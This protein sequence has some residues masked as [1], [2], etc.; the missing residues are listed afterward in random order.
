M[1]K[2]VKNVQFQLNDEQNKQFEAIKAAQNLSTNN[3]FFA[4]ILAL[5]AEKQSAAAAVK[6]ALENVKTADVIRTFVKQT[7]RTGI[8]G[9]KINQY[10]AN[11]YLA[12]VRGKENARANAKTLILIFAEFAAQIDK[13]NDAVEAA[14]AADK[15]N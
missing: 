13:H 3:D 7:L 15:A 6:N 9:G 8:S 10:T 14:D 5:C 1:K 12:D 11:K 2:Q 4:Y